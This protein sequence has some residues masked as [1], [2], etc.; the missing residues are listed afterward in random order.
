[1]PA[2]AQT[3]TPTA[4]PTSVPGAPNCDIVF[5]CE[6]D[7]GLTG[8]IDVLRGGQW[9]V[10]GGTPTGNAAYLAGNNFTSRAT[11]VTLTPGS[12]YTLTAWYMFTHPQT[13]LT[14]D[15][16]E[17]SDPN[18][19]SFTSCVITNPGA[20]IWRQ[21]RLDFSA[22]TAQTYYL[23]IGSDPWQ[24]AL[25]VDQ[26][27]IVPLGP[28][29]TPT[30]PPTATTQPGTPGGCRDYEIPSDGQPHTVIDDWYIPGNSG[31]TQSFYMSSVSGQGAVRWY[32]YNLT[33]PFYPANV[34]HSGQ[35]QGGS[36]WRFED[37]FSGQN[38]ASDN[39]TPVAIP[40]TLRVCLPPPPVATA[41]P[42]ATRSATATPTRS[43]TSTPPATST[44]TIASTA[45]ATT[46]STTV[47]E[48]PTSTPPGAPSPTSTSP[49]SA[50]ATPTLAAFP[51]QTPRPA[52]L[53]TA[54]P[55]PTSNDGPLPDLGVIIPTLRPLMPITA[56]ITISA[57]AILGAVQTMQAGVST[58]AAAVATASAAY[59]W[60]SGQQTAAA[61]STTMQPALD[62]LAILNP[63]NSLWTLGDGPLWAI[64]PL[65]LPILPIFGVGIVIVGIRFFLWLS[66]WFLKVVDLVVKLIELIPGE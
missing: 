21:C 61:W 52:P 14:I 49:G 60:T 28:T 29:P 5:N 53:V 65:I 1:M 10:I 41:T 38:S 32:Y 66:A 42:T 35:Y 43:P 46:T 13:G 63:A 15:V 8:W 9:S 51:A 16:V 48:S 3:A 19:T 37:A 59:S 24:G 40:A 18:A 44:A 6:F 34:G 39:G 27:A 30:I 62:W 26:V 2:N 12:S 54:V 50:T 22:R 56:T 20:G 7:E 17:G 25:Y 57:T 33:L 45:T 31:T 4:T 55:A 47:R 58:P 11:R 36:T 64:A 23:K